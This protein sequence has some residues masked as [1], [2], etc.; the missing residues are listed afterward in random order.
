MS[1]SLYKQIFSSKY[2]L[3]I[4]M[5]E[6]LT[7]ISQDSQEYIKCNFFLERQTKLHDHFTRKQYKLPVGLKS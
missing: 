4:L 7:L 2:I 1:K 5:K 3:I 6:I